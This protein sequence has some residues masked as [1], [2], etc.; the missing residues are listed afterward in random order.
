MLEQKDLRFASRGPLEA[1]TFPLL[2]GICLAVL[3][4]VYLL[5]IFSYYLSFI[6]YYLF[7]WL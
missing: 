2:A 3:Y 4:T 1:R 7:T 5:L 6:I